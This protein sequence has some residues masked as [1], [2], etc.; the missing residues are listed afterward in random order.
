MA[1]T[2]HLIMVA[3]DD[4]SVKISWRYVVLQFGGGTREVLYSLQRL[5]L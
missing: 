4:A 2:K 1:F 3:C 5:F